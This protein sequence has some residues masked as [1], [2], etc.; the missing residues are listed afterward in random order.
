MP[1]ATDRNDKALFVHLW[2]QGLH[3]S[4]MIYG[5][6]RLI[7]HD[8]KLHTYCV[9]LESLMCSQSTPETTF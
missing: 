5:L 2:N 6:Q 8:C 7:C 4:E 9:E 1:T 3:C